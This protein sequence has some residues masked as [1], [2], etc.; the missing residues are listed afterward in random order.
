MWKQAEVILGQKKKGEVINI[1][2]LSSWGQ[3]FGGLGE[4]GGGGCNSETYFNL[5]FQ[6]A[7]L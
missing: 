4:S 6:D 5:Y 7:S 2:I 1:I 3:F